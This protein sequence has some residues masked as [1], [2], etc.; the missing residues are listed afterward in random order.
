MS[1][2]DKQVAGAH[3]GGGVHQ[4]W[5]IVVEHDLDYFQGQITKYAMRCRKKN[6]KQDLEKC[7]H[8]VEK[9]LEVY[10]QMYP[11]EPKRDPGSW[12]PVKGGTGDKPYIE[13]VNQIGKV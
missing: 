9:Y 10:D 13:G 3:Y 6:G 11:P 7:R 4:H 5:D 8:F 12:I 2:N 1:A